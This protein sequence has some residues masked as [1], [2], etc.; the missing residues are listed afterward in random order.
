MQ[1]GD[2]VKLC[3][4]TKQVHH[5]IVLKINKS[6]GDLAGN[7]LIQWVGVFNDR[8][9]VHLLRDIQTFPINKNT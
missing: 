8:T 2:L 7:V 6:C 5:G 3:W 1:I 4:R 9:Q